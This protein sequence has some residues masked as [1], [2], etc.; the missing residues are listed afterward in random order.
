M[1]GH[2]IT[3]PGVG[4]RTL[5]EIQR[6]FADAVLLDKLEE[7]LVE[8]CVVRLMHVGGGPFEHTID[9]YVQAEAESLRDLLGK[10]IEG[11]EG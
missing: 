7:L 11:E 10:M 9:G 5:N 8:R 2:F 4:T 3:I 1:V 6:A